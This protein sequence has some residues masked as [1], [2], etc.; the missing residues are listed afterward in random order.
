[1]GV[2][3]VSDVRALT[4]ADHAE[5]TVVYAALHNIWHNGAENAMAAAKGP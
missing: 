1:M 3:P 4:L 5:T 2:W